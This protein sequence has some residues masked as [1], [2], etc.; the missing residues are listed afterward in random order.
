MLICYHLLR[1]LGCWGIPNQPILSRQ[2]EFQIKPRLSLISYKE[3]TLKIFG[4]G[5]MWS[6][7]KPNTVI[8]LF[9]NK[10]KNDI[11]CCIKNWYWTEHLSLLDIRYC[12]FFPLVVLINL[13]D[14]IWGNVSSNQKHLRIIDIEWPWNVLEAR[15]LYSHEIVT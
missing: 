9:I 5:E 12:C 14:L 1:F 11:L 8:F 4:C 15:V 2:S 7:D 13:S 10:F 6:G 3:A